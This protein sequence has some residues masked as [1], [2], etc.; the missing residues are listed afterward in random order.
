MKLE[1]RVR[2]KQESFLGLQGLS[3]SVRDRLIERW[4]D[5]QL[6]FKRKDPKRIYFLS[7]EYL[8]GI[9]VF[10]CIILLFVT[11]ISEMLIFSRLVDSF[12]SFFYFVS[13][14]GLFACDPSLSKT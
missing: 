10:F 1:V 12:F 13:R 5:T 8:M 2:L 14:F 11:I 3:H 7:L 4:H 9:F 6:Y